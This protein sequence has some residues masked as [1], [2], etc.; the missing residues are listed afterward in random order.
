MPLPSHIRGSI[1]SIFQR[2][3]PPKRSGHSNNTGPDQAVVKSWAQASM[4]TQIAKNRPKDFSKLCYTSDMA[5]SV[6]LE[7]P[8]RLL[9]AAESQARQDN[10]SL[11]EVLLE[12][13][14]QGADVPVGVLSDAQILA[15]TR[16][17][18]TDVQQTRLTA[19]LNKQRETKLT[20][21]ETSELASL[22]NLYRRG[23]VRKAE[24]HKIAVERGL[25]PPLS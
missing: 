11:E 10:R 17:Q 9:S 14:S 13:L 7:V 19:L 20:Q 24:A 18:M 21:S 4:N 12:W 25:I 3:A 2:T 15:L 22:M 1:T 16:S 23:T 8:E 6:T 5:Q